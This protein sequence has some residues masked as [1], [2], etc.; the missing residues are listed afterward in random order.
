MKI[1]NPW[2]STEGSKYFDLTGKKCLYRSGDVKVYKQH[3]Q[4]YLF[5]YKGAAI[6]QLAGPNKDHADRIA[7]G[8][9]PEEGPQKFLYDR[10]MEEIQ[11][12]F[13]Q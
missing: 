8:K 1:L 4:C 5:T 9:R 11:K 13:G 12:Q 6:N 7:K 10:A 2:A 3:E